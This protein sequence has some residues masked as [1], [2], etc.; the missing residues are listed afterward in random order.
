MGVSAIGAAVAGFIL[1]LT[2]GVRLGVSGR[3]SS[4]VIYGQS[5]ALIP[6]DPGRFLWH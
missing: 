5:S 1:V 2:R 3:K 6:V 4:L